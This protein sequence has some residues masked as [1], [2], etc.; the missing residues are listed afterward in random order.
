M[1]EE[2]EK[3]TNL[4]MIKAGGKISI[5]APLLSLTG[6]QLRERIR[7]NSVLRARWMSKK[8]SP[9]SQSVAIHRDAIPGDEEMI[10][11]SEADVAEQMQKEDASVRSGLEKMGLKKSTLDMAMA[12]REL[13]GKHFGSC[14]Q[15]T[16]GG[17]TKQ[18]LQV[19][20]EIEKIDARLDP[21]TVK[22]FPM[23]LQEESMLRE[24]RRGLLQVMSQ[25]SDRVNSSALI[26]AKIWKMKNDGR[27]KKDDRP[28]GVL[29]LAS[30]AT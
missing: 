5:A 13:A 12:V 10:L 27:G 6:M 8:D 26:Q 17:V 28:K 4:A 7:G 3:L 25:F 23:T 19:M 1:A 24:D 20:V 22:D 15:L 11:L 16:G 9:P 2:T 14:L 29:D 18:F 21:D 30:A